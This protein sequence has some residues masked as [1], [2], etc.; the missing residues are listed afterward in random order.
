MKRK[1]AKILTDEACGRLAL[2]KSREE[3]RAKLHKEQQVEKEKI[4]KQQVVKAVK[5]LVAE[6]A[7]EAVEMSSVMCGNN[8]TGGK[9]GQMDSVLE[10]QKSFE[11]LSLSGGSGSNTSGGSGSNSN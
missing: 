6:V 11:K 7:D 5:E 8:H 3:E 10:L 9:I 1:E 4:E 2:E